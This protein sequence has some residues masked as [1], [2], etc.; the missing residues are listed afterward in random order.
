MRFARPKSKVWRIAVIAKAGALLVGL[1][2]APASAQT[3]GPPRITPGPQD[4]VIE[5]LISVPDED[6]PIGT[7]TATGPLC[8]SGQTADLLVRS[9]GS[10]SGRRLNLLVV[11][12]FSCDDGSGTF[13]LLVR[14]HAELDPDTGVYVHP[15]PKR[16]SVLGGTGAYAGLKGAGSGEGVVVEGGFA[17]TLT[18]RVVIN[19]GRAR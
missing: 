8:S 10:E 15:I 6:M 18:G 7:F 1:A 11:R 4:V 3:E 2:A 13:L 16:W 12:G 5:A 17:E 19:S 14:V 9:A